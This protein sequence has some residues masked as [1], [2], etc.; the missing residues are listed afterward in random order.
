VMAE[1]FGEWR[2]GSSPCGGALVLWLRDLVPG[3]GWGVLDHRGSPKVAYHHLRRALAPSAVWMIDEGLNGVDVHVA[4]DGPRELAAKLR[5]SLYREL[6]HCVEETTRIIELPPHSIRRWGAEELLGRFVDASWA[7]RF[8]PPPHDLIV[9]SLEGNGEEQPGLIS[10]AMRFPAGRPLEAELATRLGLQS[11]VTELNDN[12]LML[13]VKTTRL[14]YG[15]RLHVPGFS[16]EE[17]AFSVAPGGERIVQL[18]PVEKHASFA[19]GRMT[20]VNLQGQ[21]PIADAR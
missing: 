21:L 15:V 2:R 3:A 20:A 8:G 6:E 4:N 17:D 18:H 16:P 13:S 10:Q 5:L 7:Y 11:S 14:A 1:V 19:G 9:A 12:A